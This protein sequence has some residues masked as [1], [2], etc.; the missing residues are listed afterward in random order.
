[1]QQRFD[2]VLDTIGGPYEGASRRVLAPGGLLAAVGATG[3]DVKTV[4][5][6]GMVALLGNAL[7][8]TLLGWLRLGHKYKL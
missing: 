7:M 2:Y 5:V 4:S 1:V 6:L 3:P 8:R